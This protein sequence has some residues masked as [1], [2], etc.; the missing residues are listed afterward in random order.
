MNKFNTT[1]DKVKKKIYWPI[2][3]MTLLV[4]VT[5]LIVYQ[6]KTEKRFAVVHLYAKNGIAFNLSKNFNLAGFTSFNTTNGAILAEGGDLLGINNTFVHFKN[7]KE[8]SMH[9]TNDEDSVVF[10][11]GKVNS[12]VISGKEDLLPWFRTMNAA[13]VADLKSIRFSSKIPPSYIPFLKELGRLKPNTDLVIEAADSVNLL[14]D[15]IKQADFFNPRFVN[16]TI[17]QQQLPLLNHWKT[18]ECLYLDIADSFV[19]VPLPAMP[20][21]KQCIIYGDGLKSITTSF[22]NN[23]TQLEKLTLIKGLGNYALLKPLDKLQEIS[24][25]ITDKHADISALKDKLSNL[26]VL[27]IS[28]NF[29]NIDWLADLKELRWIG[30]PKNTSQQQFNTIA[31]QLKGLEVLEL[32]GNDSIANLSALQQLHNLKGLVI[33]DT[34]IDKQALYMLKDLRFLSVPCNNNADSAYMLALQKALPGCIV[35]PNSGACLGSGWLLLVLPMAFLFML[36]LRYMQK[37]PAGYET[38]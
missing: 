12:I 20:S 27:I 38:T 33:T 6:F 4:G 25:N 34:V 30:L 13:V 15:I 24:F 8:D 18:I 9:V 36:C 10:V 22:F 31:A 19:T 5:A 2:I 16:A 26:S 35:V 32:Q 11:N 17:A 1:G 29:D 14:D 3:F 7:V 37:K 23:N 28:G 21:L